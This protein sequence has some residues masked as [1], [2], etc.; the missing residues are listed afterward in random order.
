[1][2]DALDI[3][4]RRGRGVVIAAVTGDVDISTVRRLRECLFKLADSGRTPIV[5]LNQ[6]TFIDSAGLGVL[7][8]RTSGP[9]AW[10]MAVRH[11]KERHRGGSV[12]V[13][14]GREVTCADGV[15]TAGRFARPGRTPASGVRSRYHRSSSVRVAEARPP[16]CWPASTRPTRTGYPRG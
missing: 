2:G 3:T 13:K 7:A 12:L 9:V 1:M 5:D 6:V 14:G 15:V 8:R 11:E 10:S 4:V 16:W